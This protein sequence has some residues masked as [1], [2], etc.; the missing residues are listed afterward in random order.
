VK[1]KRVFVRENK[2]RKV[3]FTDQTI[4]SYYWFN[5]S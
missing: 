4:F 1:A 5:D 2:Y 3:N